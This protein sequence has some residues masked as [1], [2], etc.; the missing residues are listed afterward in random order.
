MIVNH[1]TFIDAVEI[2]DRYG[3]K[4]F[5]VRLI[6]TP[7]GLNKVPAHGGHGHLDATDDHAQL[8]TWGRQY[9]T[10]AIGVPCRPNDFDV[11]D[12]DAHHPRHEED[13]H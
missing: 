8:E 10:D 3:L 1:P 12:D 13:L 9:A 4:I 6:S 5:P 11:V 2:A 7:K